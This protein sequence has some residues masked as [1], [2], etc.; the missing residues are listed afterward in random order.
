MEWKELRG[1]QAA[2]GPGNFAAILLKNQ[3]KELMKN[4]I[5]GFSVGLEDDSD[6]FVWRATIEGPVGTL[7]Y[8]QG[9]P[10]SIVLRRG[11][12]DKK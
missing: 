10:S 6:I 4:P 7:L 1:N 2:A 3:L 9:H 5:D 11:P 8:A 12:F